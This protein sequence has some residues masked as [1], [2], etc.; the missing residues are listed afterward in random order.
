MNV[1]AANEPTYFESRA[2]RAHNSRVNKRAVLGIL[3]LLLL[4]LVLP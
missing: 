2:V 3:I 1:H 4:S